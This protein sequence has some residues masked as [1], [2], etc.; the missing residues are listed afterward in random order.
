MLTDDAMIALVREHLR[1]AV[2][3]VRL[4]DPEFE[5][6]RP[7]GVSQADH[8]HA[9]APGD[10]D[11]DR[12]FALRPPAESMNRWIKERLRDRRAPAVGIKKQHF[13]LLCAGL[14]N[15]VRA[16]LAQIERLSKVA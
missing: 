16:V 12:L 15:N 3:L 6:R 10:D 7:G 4:D 1:G 5:T 2:V 9:I 11:W 13:A 14:Y 8:L